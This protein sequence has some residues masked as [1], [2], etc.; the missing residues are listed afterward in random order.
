MVATSRWSI[1]KWACEP[2]VLLNKQCAV[3]STKREQCTP[4]AQ[5]S[6]R[7]TAPKYPIARDCHCRGQAQARTDVHLRQSRQGH[8]G[9]QDHL[10]P[11]SGYHAHARIGKQRASARGFARY[12]QL[13]AIS[14]SSLCESIGDVLDHCNVPT[15]ASN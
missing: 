9:R 13:F 1:L 8:K 6:D 10:V 12:M 11:T 15:L 3:A 4:T 14:I 5:R 7:R 2:R